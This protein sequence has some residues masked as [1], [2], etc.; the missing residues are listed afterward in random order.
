MVNCELSP[1]FTQGHSPLLDIHAIDAYIFWSLLFFMLPYARLPFSFK[2]TCFHCFWLSFGG[3]VHFA[4][5]WSWDP[6]LKHFPGVRSVHLLSEVPA[7]RAFPLSCLI[8]LKH[9][10]AEW[11]LSPLKVHFFWTVFSISLFLPK[12]QLISIFR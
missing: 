1:K 4:I 12:P 10:S 5:R 3:L 8:L 2:R 11:L 9:F 6:H 7:A